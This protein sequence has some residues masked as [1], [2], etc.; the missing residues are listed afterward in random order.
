MTLSVISD[1]IFD[2]QQLAFSLIQRQAVTVHE[3]MSF[4]GKTRLLWQ[5]T[6]TALPVVLC[7][8]K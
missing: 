5:W 4:L 7:H 8:S 6:C 2:I 3:V 1:K